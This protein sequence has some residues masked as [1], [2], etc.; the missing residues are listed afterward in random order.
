MG[1]ICFLTFKIHQDGITGRHA[2][3]D[4]VLF[5]QIPDLIKLLEP[6]NLSGGY[7]LFG[8]DAFCLLEVPFWNT[9]LP[10]QEALY[11]EGLSL[12]GD[13]TGVQTVPFFYP[14]KLGIL[15]CNIPVS[16]CRLWISK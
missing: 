7:R 16:L 14:E 4:E 11:R 13:D 6:A 1:K 8:T 15:F 3:F 10:V 12:C 9:F 5:S 2:P